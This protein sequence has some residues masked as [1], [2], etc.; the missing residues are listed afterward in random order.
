MPHGAQTIQ[1]S[2]EKAVDLP[3]GSSLPRRD[4]PPLG[5]APAALQWGP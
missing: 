2:N 1:E 3:P 4:G 5:H